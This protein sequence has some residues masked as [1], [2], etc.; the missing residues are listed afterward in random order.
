MKEV[1][2]KIDINTG[3]A[4]KE[5]KGVEQAIKSVEE[6][7]DKAGKNAGKNIKKV[8]DTSKKASKG[9][10]KI[11]AAF[12]TLGATMKAAGIGLI[13]AGVLAL[14]KAFTQNQKI[15]DK[16][17][18][19]FE[20]ISGVFNQI[21]TALVDTY[22]A[23][24]NATN[25]FESIKTVMSSLL[26]VAVTPLK[27]AF[28]G[29]KLGVQEAQLAWE[30]SFFGGKDAETMKQLQ[31]DIIATKEA[32]FE[33]GEEAIQAGKDYVT[34]I[35]GVITELSEI[36]TTATG[37]LSEVSVKAAN[38]QAK[39][40]VNIRNA[41]QL[42]A[43]EQAKLAAKYETEAELL[44]QIRDD[45]TKSFKERSKASKDLEKV[46][47]K[48][49]KALKAQADLQVEAAKQEL[50]KNKTIENQV[51]LT[52]ALTNAQSV[53][54]DVTGKLSEQKTSDVALTKE[55]TDAYNAQS[56]SLNQNSIE[57]KR[58]NAELIE[59]KVESL[60]ALRVVFEEEKQIELERLQGIID[61]AN[62]DTQAKI[63]AETALREKK[64]EFRQ[65]DKELEEQ[66]SEAK[67]EAELKKTEDEE[68]GFELERERLNERRN[69]ILND[70]TL[71]A[72]KRMALLKTVNDAEKKLDRERLESKRQTLNG[73]LTLFGAETAAGKAALVAKQLLNAQ[74]LLQDIKKINWKA[75]KT[76]AEASMD[77]A[78]GLAKTAAV[79]FPQN[80]PLLIGY[81]AQ[82]VGIFSAIKGAVSSAKATG[83][84]VS[85]PSAPP[86]V[87]APKA[88]A[89]SFNIVGQSETNQLADAIGGQTQKPIKTYVLS[90]DVETATAFD[91]SVESTS[92]IG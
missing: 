37:K 38:E 10:G 42:A 23:V 58:F 33:T 18:I 39:N 7:S 77:N 85:A 11:S 8:G 73:I 26:T 60:E 82:A 81:A 9:V 25:G 71:S 91:R 32:I 86:S 50:A 57:A 68:I 30:Q 47:K 89:S 34:N 41:A 5:I 31:L 40:L 63:D 20:T 1:N 90:S 43:A 15:M 48:Q 35:G 80:I 62:A 17:N 45:T 36:A 14:T 49:N 44:R 21:V 69:T 59:D 67:S 74:E 52:E 54:A 65:Q 27:L 76:V 64:E 3:D 16:V 12:K 51:A 78:A 22:D 88:T 29:I 84:N 28:F 72:E 79:G 6:E 53:Q 56:E 61:R 87:A 24:S 55:Q 70:E 19:V 46:L 75:T 2:V 13:V 92:S 4:I 83:A 66:T